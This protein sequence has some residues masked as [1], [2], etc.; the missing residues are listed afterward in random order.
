MLK[1]LVVSKEC[2]VYKS[3]KYANFLIIIFKKVF[4]YFSTCFQQF[5]HLINNIYCTLFFVL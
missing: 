4:N 1:N 3:L 5:L 2:L